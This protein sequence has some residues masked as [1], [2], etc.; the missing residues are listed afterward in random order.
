VHGSDV[1]GIPAVRLV[2][3]GREFRRLLA[4]RLSSQAADGIFQ[5][6]LASAVFFSPERATTA[7]DAAAGFAVLLLPYSLVGP[8]A[9]VLLDRWR[10]QRV[11][12]VGNAVRALLVVGT[13]ALLASVSV[14]AAY[15][16]AALAVLSVNRFFLAAL[17]A[18][19]PH[20]VD[21]ERL[22][23]ANSL[24]TTAGAVVAIGGG[25]IGLGLRELA[26]P[27][28]VGNALVALG[29]AAAYLG[30]SLLARRLDGDLLGPDA[31]PRR[32]MSEQLGHVAHGL[33]DGARHVGERPAAWQALAVIAVHRL[34]Y[35]VSLVAT[36]LLYRNT[37]LPEGVLR[38]GLAGLGQAFAASALGFA[39]AAV[40]TPPASR[41]LGKERWIVATLG[42]ACVAELVF[43]LFYTKGALLITAV[44][45][46]VAAQG[47]KICVDTIVQEAVE[48]NYRGRVFSLYDTLFNVTLVASATLAAVVVPPSGRS[49]PLIVGIAAIYAVGA[50]GYALAQRRARVRGDLAVR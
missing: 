21:R 35:G 31:V 12:V 18:S 48:D 23:L 40:V 43:G 11:L 16:A 24:T 47:S 14:G 28:D 33:V 25:G 22:V 42:A 38:T 19:L 9:G 29:A 50:A 2:L 46:G 7:A 15:Y 44:V 8:F 30:S 1:S 4:T 17:G 3:R 10:R 49:Q 20:V 36:L 5:A 13:A 32:P 26:G 39:V 6:S 41:R 34:A 37:Y 27:G 45:L